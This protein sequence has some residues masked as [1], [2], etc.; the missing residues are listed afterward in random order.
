MNI[1]ELIKQLQEILAPEFIVKSIDSINFKPHPYCITHH[2]LSR[3]SSMHLGKEQ[4]EA[5][6]KKHGPMCGV[7]GC[8]VYYEQHTSDK[9]CFLQLTQN[10]QQSVAQEKLKSAIPI[11]TEN[12]IDGF[13][14][15]DTREKF[16][17]T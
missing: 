7:P 16:R 11:L 2:H 8:N 15:V 6:E 10:L 17:I 14:F 1:E 3:N 5:M 4:I 12:K 9:A 13:V